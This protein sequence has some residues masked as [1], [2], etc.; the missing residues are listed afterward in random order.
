MKQ[1]L[2][3]FSLIIAL[4]LFAKSSFAFDDGDWQFW[5][6]QTF[7]GKLNENWGVTF[8]EELRYGDDMSSFFREHS[9]LAVSY[10]ISDEWFCSAHFKYIYKKKSGDWQKE[11]R[12]YLNFSYKF[13]I[14]EI[15]FKNKV[16]AEYRD[17]ETNDFYRFRNQL[18]ATFPKLF[19]KY[20]TYISEEIF[21]DTEDDEINRNRLKF[22]I[23]THLFSKLYGETYYLWQTDKKDSW[24]DTNIIGLK[25]KIK[26]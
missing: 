7:S 12:P 6:N 24:V 19:D 20:T 18:T 26:F 15:K 25:L 4:L 10:K 2:L 5:F 22:G 23:K 13:K 3:Q 17:K 1:K 9:D 14:N 11:T 8:S 21:I 16:Q